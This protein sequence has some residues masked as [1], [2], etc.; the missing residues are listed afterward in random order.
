MDHDSYTEVT[1][2]PWGNRLGGS[3][4]G[5]LVGLGLVA[6]TVVPL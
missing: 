4:K 2:R 3:V 6:G 1:T 5:I